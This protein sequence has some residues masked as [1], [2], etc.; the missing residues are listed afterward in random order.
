MLS[1]THSAPPATAPFQGIPKPAADRRR[2]EQ[3]CQ[4]NCHTPPASNRYPTGDTGRGRKNTPA[5]NRN[6]NG[7]ELKVT[8]AGPTQ[9]ASSIANLESG[10]K[11][12]RQEILS[13]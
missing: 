2:S 8:P 7:R 11:H 10:R 3:I 1:G 5:A 9:R 4:A 13:T 12:I 6:K